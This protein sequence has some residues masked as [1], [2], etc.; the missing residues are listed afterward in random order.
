MTSV[1][2]VPAASADSN[3]ILRAFVA[4]LNGEN[5]PVDAEKA[6]EILA[7]AARDG[8]MQSTVRLIARQ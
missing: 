2:P 7:E 1:L 3:E 4:L 8:A 5:Q 6:L